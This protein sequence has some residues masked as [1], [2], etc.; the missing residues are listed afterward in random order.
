MT[1]R[2]QGLVM[3]FLTL[4]LA[5]A[6]T[7]PAVAQQAAS[8]APVGVVRV[9]DKT[10][11]ALTDL[12]LARGQTSGVGL[13]TV[14][15]NDCRYP[16]GA[17]QADAFGELQ[18]RYGDAADVVFD[19]WMIASSPALNPLDHPRYDVWMLRCKTE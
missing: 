5:L 17:I 11:G 18:I 19:G 10:T 8:S 2:A 1:R 15:L 16:A 13:L 4:C 6:V 7:G 9:L 12:P 14:T 3:R